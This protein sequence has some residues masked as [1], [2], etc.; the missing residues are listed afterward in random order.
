MFYICLGSRG[1]SFREQICKRKITGFKSTGFRA[2]G[3]GMPL[4]SASQEANA[5]GS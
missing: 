5:A 3:G 4:I 1:F 2:R